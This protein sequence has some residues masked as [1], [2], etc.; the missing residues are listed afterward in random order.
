MVAEAQPP[1]LIVFLQVSPCVTYIT[2]NSRQ[3]Y[4]GNSRGRNE[5]SRTR[6]RIKYG[7]PDAFADWHD[8]RHCPASSGYDACTS[9]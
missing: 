9:Y 1:A 4:I 3:C 8:R 5:A 6:G 2:D 7:Y